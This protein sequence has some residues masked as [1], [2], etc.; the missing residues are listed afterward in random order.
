[1]QHAIILA[2]GSNTRLGRGG[3]AYQ[4]K[5]LLPR[6][7]G[8]TL[9]YFAYERLKGVVT[10][11]HRYVCASQS[12]RQLICGSLSPPL[13]QYLGE[14]VSRDSLKALGFCAA[15]VTN[16]NLQAIMGGCAAD[17][18]I[19]PVEQLQEIFVQGFALAE[20]NPQ[21]LV[22]F[23]IV[24]TTVPT[25]YGYLQLGQAVKGSACRVDCFRMEQDTLLAAEFFPSDH[26][27][28]FLNNGRFLWQA[29]ILQDWIHRYELSTHSGL[30]R[31]ALVRYIDVLAPFGLDR[32]I[33][34]QLRAVSDLSLEP[35]L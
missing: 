7:S 14:P 18:I 22:T 34:E 28:Y 5:Q 21:A 10:S 24:S 19:T 17:H 15:V 11:D 29:A 6:S 31:M 8:Q 4:P 3:Q 27:H 16:R 33:L 12:H 20:E 30:M 23:G 25:A 2:G 26:Q 32:A 13:A 9:F 35:N 1:M